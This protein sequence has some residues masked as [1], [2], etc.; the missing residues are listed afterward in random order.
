MLLIVTGLFSQERQRESYYQDK[1]AVAING[2]TEII[3]PDR[4]RV[5]IVTETHAIEVDFAEKWAESGFQCLHYARSL[6]KKAGIL[7]VWEGPEDERYLIRLL[8][9]ISENNLPINVWVWN[10]TN[11]TWSHVDYFLDCELKYIY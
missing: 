9:V 8:G 6:N 2:K 11:D 3:L 10:W 1:F 4:T 5:D 7:L